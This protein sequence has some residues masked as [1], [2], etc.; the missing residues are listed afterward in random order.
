MARSKDLATKVVRSRHYTAGG[1]PLLN[2]DIYA[3][4][5]VGRPKGLIK[6]FRDTSRRS[7]AAL[8]VWLT[9]V[10]ARVSSRGQTFAEGGDGQSFGGCYHQVYE[11]KSKGPPS[12]PRAKHPLFPD[13]GAYKRRLLSLPLL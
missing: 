1:S 5:A 7:G 6:G 12:H 2:S 3:S 4:G 8:R 11:L 13:A 10:S 9:C